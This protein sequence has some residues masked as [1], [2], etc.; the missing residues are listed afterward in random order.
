MNNPLKNVKWKDFY[1]SWLFWFLF[2]GFW[3]WGNYT[4]IMQGWG[5]GVI[6]AGVNVVWGFALAHVAYGF[7]LL[8][9]GK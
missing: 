3:I 2:V 9:K 5:L 7:V 1:K 6:S 4:D 8:A